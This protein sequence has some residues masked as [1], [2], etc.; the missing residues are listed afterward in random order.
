[1]YTIP[2][3]FTTMHRQSLEA[4]QEMAMASLAGWEKLAELNLQATKAS[5]KEGVEQGVTLLETRDPKALGETFAEQ[6]QPAGDKI[7]AYAKHVAEIANQTGTELSR[8]VEKQMSEANRQMFTAVDAMAKSAPAGSEG[9]M[10]MMKSA[11]TAAN[12]T[13]DQV[14]KASKQVVEMTEANVANVTR[15]AAKAAPRKAA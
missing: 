7:N 4:M 3:Q 6:A 12:S 15:Q 9:L 10:T 1:M 13:W 5:I 8:I 14:N 11:M 2:E